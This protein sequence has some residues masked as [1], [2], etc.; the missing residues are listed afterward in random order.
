MLASL[1]CES[2]PKEEGG[3]AA[4]A[5]EQASIGQDVSTVLQVTKAYQLCTQVAGAMLAQ[6]EGTKADIPEDF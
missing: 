2:V 4:A 3:K 5:E 6:F 1:R